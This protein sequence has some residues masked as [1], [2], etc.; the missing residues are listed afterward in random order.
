MRSPSSLLFPPNN[1]RWY[2]R[3]VRKGRAASWPDF[4]ACMRRSASASR[5]R[6]ATSDHLLF[7]QWLRVPGHK[8]PDR[9]NMCARCHRSAADRWRRSIGRIAHVASALARNPWNG[10]QSVRGHR[11]DATWVTCWINASDHRSATVVLLGSSPSLR[12][13]ERRRRQRTREGRYPRPGAD[14]NRGPKPYP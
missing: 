2:G 10:Y 12:I 8:W 1:G 7:G 4:R 6:P 14:S 9:M 3:K 11:A 5:L 13:V